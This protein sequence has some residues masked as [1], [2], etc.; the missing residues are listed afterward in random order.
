MLPVYLQNKLKSLRINSL[1]ELQKYN[2]FLIFQWLRDIYPSMGFRVLFDLYCLSHNQSLNTLD[3]EIKA[4]LKLTYKSLPPHFAPLPKDEIK[5]FMQIALA[6]ARESDNEIP[7]GAV[8]VKDSQVIGWGNNQ[9]IKTNDI[10]AHAEI[11]AICDASKTLGNYRLDECDLYVTIEP[12][13][14]CS[15]AIINSRIRRVIFGAQ[16][17]KTGALIS[18][19]KILNNTNI[20]KHTEAIGPIDND[21]YSAPLR[22]FL[23]QKR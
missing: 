17:P 10:T 1:E 7:I 3:P 9:T 19:Y 22:D 13:L 6:I 23:K 20:N 4:K 15:G 16:E 2:Y 5:K 18:Q 8:V 21:L 12:C 14:M 11:V